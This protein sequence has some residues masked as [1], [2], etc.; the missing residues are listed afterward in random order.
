MHARCSCITAD[1][2]NLETGWL[3]HLA[4]LKSLLG[5]VSPSQQ[6]E[7]QTTPS[8]TVGRLAS[9]W[10]FARADYQAAYLNRQETLLDTNDLA[11]WNS[12]GLE[13][14]QDASLYKSTEHV[15]NDPR[16]CPI[17]AVNLGILVSPDEAKS[18]LHSSVKFN[19]LV[20]V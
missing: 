11:L 4:G 19:L 20:S 15:K 18:N 6:I 13:V 17:P 3:Q 7:N 2:D 14:Q 9:F 12:C 8:L 10:N 5:A 16:H 1:L